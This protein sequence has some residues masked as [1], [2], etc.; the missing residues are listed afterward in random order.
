MLAST[1]SKAL[2]GEIKTFYLSPGFLGVLSA[3]TVLGGLILWCRSNFW[4][5]RLGLMGQLFSIEPLGK[6]AWY[7]KAIL[8]L[9]GWRSWLLS[10]A[11]NWVGELFMMQSASCET[12][13]LFFVI[14]ILK[15]IKI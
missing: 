10:W 5:T 3:L 7:V 12:I 8:G 11:G 9:L 1:L 14:L 15:L 2:G 6:L 4:V 13:I